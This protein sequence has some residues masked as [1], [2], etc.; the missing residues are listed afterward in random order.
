MIA[1]LGMY[2]RPELQGANDRYWALIRDGLRAQGVAA[3][4]GLTRGAEAYMAGW[5]S[6]DLVL[7]QT[8]GLPY[9]AVLHRDVT[10]IGTPDFGVE[11]CPPGYYR[12]VL[13]ARSDDPR[14]SAP[15]FAPSRFAYNDGL[16]QS[17]WAAAQAHFASLGLGLAPALCTAGH[18]AS[19]RSVYEGRADFAAI[20][21]VTW[22]LLQRHESWTSG[23]R[24]W[25]QT[26][27]NPGLPYIAAKGAPAAALF[28]AVAQ[29][30]AALD[31]E[32]RHNLGLRGLVAIPSESYLAL[33]LPPAP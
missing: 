33:P 10:L 19:A 31:A 25:A 6:R 11:G 14:D 13:I 18:A 5:Q 23:L 16:S 1:A 3:P 24:V 7:S 27:P 2:D 20:D 21:A 26:A 30:I 32:D 4:D 9:R 17:G 29:A 8:C 28:S 12:S 15:D 22:A